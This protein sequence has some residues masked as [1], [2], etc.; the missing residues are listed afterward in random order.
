M[1]A[2]TPTSIISQAWGSVMARA[3]PR[4]DAVHVSGARD[5]LLTLYSASERHYHDARHIAAV[6][7]DWQSYG[8]PADAVTLA[9]LYHDAIYDP[10][11]QDNEALSAEL[12]VDR[13]RALG[14]NNGMLAR[15]AD[16]VLATRHMAQ[17]A[18]PSDPQT[19]LFLDCDLAILA[20]EPAGYRDYAGAIR[21][22]FAHV[23]DVAYRTGRTH[24]LRTFLARSAIYMTPDRR[25]SWEAAARRNIVDE[26]E[27]LASVMIEKSV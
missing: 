25:Q 19:A 10:K 26:I 1:P 8:T 23:P 15:V 5:E 2:M 13:L 4:A 12:A 6:L 3:A 21:R 20:S 24:V 17:A 14:C 18:T 16:L 22:E 27:A 9:I 7:G 11:R